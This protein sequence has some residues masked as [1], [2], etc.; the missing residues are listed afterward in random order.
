M[1]ALGVKAVEVA[2]SKS[3][4]KWPDIWVEGDRVPPRITVT[5]EWARQGVHERRSRLT[6]EI[7]HLRG[8]EH[9]QHEGLEF[10]TYPDEDEYSRAV[11]WGL[12]NG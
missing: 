7:L 4:A 1:P 9:G 12:L 5:A 3:R 11:Y 8:L 6:H 2:W 10:S